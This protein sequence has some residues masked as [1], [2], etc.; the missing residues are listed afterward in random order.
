M[1]MTAFFF[2]NE[3]H[4]KAYRLPVTSYRLPG[5][6]VYLLAGYADGCGKRVEQ[7]VST[8]NPDNPL[9]FNP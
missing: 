8:F 9:I 4:A 1:Q 6:S 7:L 3:H 5:R 2:W